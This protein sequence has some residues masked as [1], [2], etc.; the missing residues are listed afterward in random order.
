MCTQVYV[1]FLILSIGFLQSDVRDM[2]Y[3][4]SISSKLSHGVIG[5]FYS[6]T[7]L[8]HSFFHWVFEGIYMI[9]EHLLSKG[10]C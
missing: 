2:K 6:I 7:E 9:I 8:D 10:E 1:Y 3:A 4:D 5:V